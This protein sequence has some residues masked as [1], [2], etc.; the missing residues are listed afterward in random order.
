M[1][2]GERDKSYHGFPGLGDMAE[3]TSVRAHVKISGRVQGVVFRESTRREAETH[4]VSGWVRN[5]PD[6]RVEAVFEGEDMDVRQLVQW[7]HKG[8]SRARVDDVQVEWEEYTGKFDDFQ[9]YFGWS[10]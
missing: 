7:C 3:M 6:G 8:P 2:D 4:W 1:V 9:I 5:L 10:W